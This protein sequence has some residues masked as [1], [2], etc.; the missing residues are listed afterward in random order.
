MADG[1]ADGYARYVVFFPMYTTGQERNAV[2]N[3]TNTKT[4]AEKKAAR[5]EKLKALFQLRDNSVPGSPEEAAAAE[6]LLESLFDVK[7]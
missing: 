5:E 3:E 7:E 2:A 6:A 1:Y 4:A